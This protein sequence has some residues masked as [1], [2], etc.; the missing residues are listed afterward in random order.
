MTGHEADVIGRRLALHLRKNHFDGCHII[1]DYEEQKLSDDE[2]P[3]AI[4]EL[5][6]PLRI[7]NFLEGAGYVYIDELRGIS[8]FDLEKSISY[9]GC[10][11]AT[12][13]G[14]VVSDAFRKI[15][16]SESAAIESGTK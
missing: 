2:P 16:K 10:A 13:V 9:L 11:G 4:A 15:R 6:L 12:L 7:I 1:L 8:V 5:D 3:K 14:K